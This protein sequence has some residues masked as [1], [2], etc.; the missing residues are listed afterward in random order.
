MPAA[1]GAMAPPGRRGQGRRHDRARD[2]DLATITIQNYFRIYQKLGG[3]TGTAET[4]AAEFHDIY[5]LDVLV[6][7]TNRPIARKD[8]NDKHLQDP[9]REIQ[10]RHRGLVK[11]RHLEGQPIL[12][13]TASVETSEVLSRMLG[14]E[15]ITHNV[16]NAKFHRQEAEIVARAGQQGSVTIATNMAGRG[17]DIKLGEGVAD[18]RRPLRDRHRAS[19]QPPR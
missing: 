5:K 9:A 8:H 7:P 11:E 15:K 1:A 2:P 19:P 12:L 10:S 13:G 17:T 18:R 3:M 14:R 6:I 16:L 4:E